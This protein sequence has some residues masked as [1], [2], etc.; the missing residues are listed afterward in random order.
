MKKYNL[1]TV[2]GWEER[3]LLGL[4]TILKDFVLES[5]ILIQFEDYLSMDNMSNN[6]AEI[7][8]LSNEYNFEI[9]DVKL[10]YND[11]IK[12]WNL[13]E[14][15]FVKSET[16]Y[17]FNI[18][19]IPRETIW[20]LF[21]F[22]KRKVE[23]LNYIYFRPKIYCNDWLT[24]NHKFPRLLFK[25]SGLFDLNKKL[26]LF[27]IAGFDNSRLEQLID[28]YEPSKIII[29]YQ[30]D[31]FF[32]NGERDLTFYK[33]AS[34]FDCKIIEI[35]TYDVGKTSNVIFDQFTE[36][37]KEYNIIIDSQ[38]PKI[39]SMSVYEVYLRSKEQMGLAYVA[40]KDFNSKYSQGIDDKYVFGEFRF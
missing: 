5:I 27:V 6:Y 23:T 13:L 22:L 17:L 26:S 18:T 28:Y 20:T 15:L 32:E 33:F 40:A 35:N 36:Y 21:F 24:R 4:K 31:N 3:F 14:Y 37:E 7:V 30:K 2:L 38:G 16:N 12:N 19:T 10:E 11:S 34:R 39:S 9:I 1:V 29:F 8:N 25:H